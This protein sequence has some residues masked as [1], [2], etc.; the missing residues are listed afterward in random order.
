LPLQQSFAGWQKDMVCPECGRS[1]APSRHYYAP[2][3]YQPSPAE[4]QERQ[5]VALANQGNSLFN[6][7]NY[8]EAIRLYKLAR[9]LSTNAASARTIEHNIANAFSWQADEAEKRGDLRTAFSMI[10]QALQYYP[11]TALNWPQWAERLQNEITARETAERQ[12]EEDR[13]ASQRRIK[14]GSLSAAETQR[15]SASERIKNATLADAEKRIA[16]ARQSLMREQ[17]RFNESPA[18]ATGAIP[19][20]GAFGTTVVP[21]SEAGAVVPPG[22]KTTYDSATAQADAAKKSASMGCVYDGQANCAPGTALPFREA[23]VL[24]GS[25]SLPPAVKS[26]MNKTPE[27]KKLI[28]EEADLRD[29]Y[30]S[31]DAKAAEL[32]VQRDA[33]ADGVARGKLAVEYEKLDEIKNGFGQKLYVKEIELETMSK[34]FVLDK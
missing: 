4:L 1:S 12:A 21:R 15:S 14:I 19:S 9:N 24:R 7:G 16:D 18:D 23:I 10:S 20:K 25:A 8:A 30:A 32:K 31:A 13:R 34:K 28:A 2:P 11:D 3:V 27:G 29:K 6:R 26:A 17:K 33:A 22:A 5:S